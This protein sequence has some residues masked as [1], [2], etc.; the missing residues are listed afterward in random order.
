MEGYIVEGNSTMIVEFLKT[1]KYCK[2]NKDRTEFCKNKLTKDKLSIYCRGC[3][4]KKTYDSYHK[5]LEKSRKRLRSYY[6]N[7]SWQFSVGRSA[8][9]K[10]KLSWELTLSEYE[11][12]IENNKCHYCPN[13][14]PKVGHGL[15]RINNSIGY[16]RDN[17]VPC[18]GVCNKMRNKF[19]THEEMIVAMAAITEYRKTLLT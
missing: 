12:I 5:D 19:L 13:V 17:V 7:P 2:E 16:R 4:N 10:R 11:Q 1:C 6:G 14:L 8:A 15:D 18:C 3:S 9:K